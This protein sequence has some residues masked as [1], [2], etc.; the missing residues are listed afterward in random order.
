MVLADQRHRAIRLDRPEAQEP[1][2]P[3]GLVVAPRASGPAASSHRPGCGR[4]AACTGRTGSRRAAADFGLVLRAERRRLAPERA[5]GGPER[6]LGE[7][8]VNSVRGRQ[9]PRE[10]GTRTVFEQFPDDLRNPTANAAIAGADDAG[11]ADIIQKSL[12][13]RFVRRERDANGNP[14]IVTRG[15]DGQEQRGYVNRPGLDLQDVSRAVYGSLPYVATGGATGAALKT[16][17]VGLNALGQAGA[18]A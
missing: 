15:P 2:R 12:G 3:A 9:D 6:G 1:G 16:A 18:A 10:A 14:I 13:D 17:G 7:W 4:A 11:M 5:A 8:L